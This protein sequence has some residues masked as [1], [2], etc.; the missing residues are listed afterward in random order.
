VKN[1]SV[2]RLCC[3]VDYILVVGEKD[4]L[5]LCAQVFQDF[6][7]RPGSGIVE[8]YEG[9]VYEKGKGLA[10]GAESFQGPKAKG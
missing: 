2:Y 1:L 6:W 4:N 5:G 9:I 8:V 10:V 7:G 3:Q